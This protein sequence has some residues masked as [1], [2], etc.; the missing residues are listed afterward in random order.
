MRKTLTD[1]GVAALKPRPQRY[2]Y[3]DPELRSHYVR[4][5]PNGGKSFVV[6]VRNPFHQQIW[7]TLG[8]AETMAIEE[9]RDK[10]RAAIRR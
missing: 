7:V 10:A 8:N 2:S 1:K 5:T 3:S 6:G 4:V 9:S